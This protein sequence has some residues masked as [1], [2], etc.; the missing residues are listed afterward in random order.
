MNEELIHFG[1]LGMKWGVRR[2]GTKGPSS[3]DHARVSQLRKKKPR[4][5]SNKEMQDVITRMSLT[6]QYKSLNPNGIAKG[7]RAVKNILGLMG[8]ITTAAATI[9]AFVITGKKIYDLYNKYN[10]GK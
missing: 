1:V 9:S 5:L 3:E 6:N 4:E 2:R 10:P 8:G 7:Q